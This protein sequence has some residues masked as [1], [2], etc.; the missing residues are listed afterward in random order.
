MLR[1][2][3]PRHML[4]RFQR[5]HKL[6]RM[7]LLQRFLQR[8]RGGHGSLQKLKKGVKERL[9]KGCDLFPE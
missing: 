3:Q 8:Q 9:Q 7:V 1:R 6:W 4:Q 2:Q 5:E